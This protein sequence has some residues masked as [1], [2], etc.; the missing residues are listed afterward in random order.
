MSS[1]RWT[2]LRCACGPSR[3]GPLLL[4]YRSSAFTP[5]P[6]GTAGPADLEIK[7]RFCKRVHTLAGVHSLDDLRTPHHWPL[8]RLGRSAA[9]TAAM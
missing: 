5:T 8:S 3:R 6:D 4:R 9:D 1:E 7:C 2:E